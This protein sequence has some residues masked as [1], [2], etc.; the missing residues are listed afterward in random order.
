MQ[1][2]RRVHAVGVCT[3]APGRVAA[4][5]DGNVLLG[6]YSAWPALAMISAGPAGTTAD[7]FAQDLRFSAAG[8]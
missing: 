1:P 7:E 3:C 5:E 2:N 8:W 6:I 4:G